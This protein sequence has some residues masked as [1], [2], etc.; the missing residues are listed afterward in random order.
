MKLSRLLVAVG[1]FTPIFLV[2]A[3]SHAANPDKISVT[4]AQIEEIG[5][6]ILKDEYPDQKAPGYALARGSL[7][8]M[9]GI[10][11]LIKDNKIDDIQKEII[12]PMQSVEA[13]WPDRESENGMKIAD[14]YW[15]CKDAATVLRLSISLLAENDTK[16]FET[17]NSLYDSQRTLCVAALLAENIKSDPE[18]LKKKSG[19]K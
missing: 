2:S 5:Q 11:M 13:A 1:V 12:S 4:R 17:L 6:S 7:A 9:N 10:A 16:Y 8:F 14:S 19:S 15:K 3:M 18:Y